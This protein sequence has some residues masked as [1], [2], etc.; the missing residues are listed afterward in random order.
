VRARVL[1]L[2]VA[3]L[4]LVPGAV[5]AQ[6]ALPSAEAI[7]EHIRVAAG[8]PVTTFRRTTVTVSSDGTTST[9][10]HIQRADGYRD[11]TEL[12]P[13]HTERGVV[14]D[15]AWHQND[16]GQTVIEQ[17]DPGNAV[18]E[19]TTTTVGRVRA[20]VDGYVIA[21]LTPGGYG[22]KDYIDASAWRLA[23]RETVGVNGTVVTDYDDVRADH[24][25]TFAHHWHTDN[26]YARTTSDTK[27]VAYDPADVPEA[28]IAMPPSR[29]RLVSFPEGVKTVVLPSQFGRSHVIVRVTIGGR[30]LDFLLDTGAGGI[31]IDSA[32]AN[33]LGLKSYAQRSAVTAGRYTTARTIVPEMRVGSLVMRDVAMQMVPQGWNE[34]SGVK[35]VGLL[36][37]DFLAELGVTIDYQ[38]QQVVAVPEPLYQPPADAHTTALDVRLGN[39]QPLTTVILNGAAGERFMLDTGGSGPMLIHDYFVRRHPDAVRD[40]GA[41]ARMRSPRFHGI[42]GDF[43]TRAYQLANV[44]IGNLRFHDFIGYRVISRGAYAGATD[45]LLGPEFLR[46]FTLGLDYAN[47]RIYLEPNADG[48]AAMGIK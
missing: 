35:S 8:P 1:R 9:Y 28:E 4:M 17:P 23:R 15:V 27:V 48:R 21:T 7:R 36:G 37:F 13:F 11:V 5:Q 47:S 29:R 46:L 42:G 18:R 19:A 6:D 41:G 25:I 10:T 45:G 32:V 39:G 2:L 40:E 16:N 31:F 33:E 44:Q 26:A 3:L 43:D 24:G 38:H 30:G 14:K 34:Q 22:T 12:G 20:P